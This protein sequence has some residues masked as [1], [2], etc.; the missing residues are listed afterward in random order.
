MS[1]P[2][3]QIQ[4]VRAFNRDYT[5]RIGVLSQ[6]LL[7]SPY[8]LTQVRVM[9]EVAHRPGVLA[10]QLA[11]ELGLDR[12]YLSRILK[13]FEVQRLLARA[14]AAEDARRQPLRLTPLG[15]RVFAP[16]ERRSQEQVRAMLAGV[17]GP[18]RAALLEAMGTIQRALTAKQ[19][20]PEISLRAHRPGDM[21]WVIERH[22]ALYFRDYGWNEEFEALVAGIAADFI[23]R[24]DPAR[25]RCWIAESQGRRLGCVFLVA[26]AGATA[27]LRLLLV[28]P[29]ARGLGLGRRLIVECVRFA[30]AARYER[31]TLWTHANLLA[32]RHLYTRAGFHKTAHQRRRSFGH[33]L[34]SETWQLE[35][36]ALARGARRAARQER[37][38]D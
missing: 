18:R 36:R 6:G 15:K 3:Q 16:L 35:L 9:Y 32:A 30:R 31:I 29:E 14:A 37:R 5:R 8:S 4:S 24:L 33:T 2:H 20:A 17:D 23:H 26:G 21:G 1:I 25:E 13:G 10:G 38:A 12:G 11:R 34:T 7:D 22:G 27:K 28:E 19:S